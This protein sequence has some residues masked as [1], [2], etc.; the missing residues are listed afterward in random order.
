MLSLLA[1]AGEPIHWLDLGLTRGIS[2]GAFTLRWYSLAYLVGIIFAYWHTLRQIKTAGAPLAQR[3]ADDLFFYCTIGVIFGGRLGYATFYEPHLWAQPLELLKLWNGGMSFHGGL[4][5]AT[6]AMA[7]VS[8]RG[9]LSFIRVCDYVSVSVPMGMLLGRLANFVNGELWGRVAGEGVNWAMV[10]PDGGPL[11]RHPS[12][13]Y[14]ASMEGAVLLI[15][16]LLLFWKT[17]RAVPPWLAGR[18]VRHR[19]RPCPVRFRIL[20]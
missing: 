11:P 17:S 14:Q 9:K 8:W 12:Q 16:M 20:P 19:H 7:W 15:I 3:H 4:I 5:G 10:F 2:L 13:L 18:R 6:L 1:A